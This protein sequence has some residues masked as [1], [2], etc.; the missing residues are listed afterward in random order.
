MNPLPF[1]EQKK[2]AW[3]DGSIA[4]KKGRPKAENPYS[5]R[6]R[7]VLH[8]LWHSG[9]NDSRHRSHLANRDKRNGKSPPSH[10]DTAP[11]SLPNPP[12]R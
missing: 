7:P 8:Q 6:K 3:L 10:N 4:F 5:K 12:L 1:S 9:Y 2:I 11:A